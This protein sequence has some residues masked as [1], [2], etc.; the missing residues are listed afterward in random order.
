VYFAQRG[1]AQLAETTGL[2]RE[3]LYKALSGEG[4]PPFSHS[5]RVRS[6]AVVMSQIDL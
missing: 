1:M 3:S 4:K 6:A 5:W 2:R